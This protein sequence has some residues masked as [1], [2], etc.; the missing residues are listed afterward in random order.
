MGTAPFT[1]QGIRSRAADAVCPKS[2]RCVTSSI[3]I[4]LSQNADPAVQ[5]GMECVKQR[6]AFW[7]D[8]DEFVRT[9]VRRAWRLSLEQLRDGSSD[10]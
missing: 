7:H 2:G 3:A 8:A 4:G 6:L 1:M 9:R 10:G 5:A